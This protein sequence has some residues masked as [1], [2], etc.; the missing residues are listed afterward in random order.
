MIVPP[1]GRN[2]GRLLLVLPEDHAAIPGA[3]SVATFRIAR[4]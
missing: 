1:S 4:V 3:R 2:T